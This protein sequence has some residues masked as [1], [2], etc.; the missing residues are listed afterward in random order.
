MCEKYNIPLTKES[1]NFLLYTTTNSFLQ[2]NMPDLTAE[3]DG[4]KIVISIIDENI[5]L[6]NW[7][8]KI[9][10]VHIGVGKFAHLP[11]TVGYM[12]FSI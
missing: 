1:E 4:I 8:E 9:G 6:K 10:F 12:E 3:Q 7:Y 2:K 5:I 11:F